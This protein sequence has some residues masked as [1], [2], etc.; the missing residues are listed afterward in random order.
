[1]TT[2][3][4]FAEMLWA[5][6]G[7]LDRGETDAA[8]AALRRQ[9]VRL[10]AL[11]TSLLDY[12]RIDPARPVIPVRPVR[13][14]TAIRRTLSQLPPPSSRRVDVA[15][16]DHVRL[17]ADEQHLDQ[18][19]VNLLGNA[20]RYGGRNIRIEAHDRDHHTELLVADDGPGIAP[21]FMSSLFEPFSRGAHA[22]ES[23]GSGLGLAIV[24]SLAVSLGGSVRYEPGIPAGARFVVSLRRAE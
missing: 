22:G 15:V 18:I 16:S 12:T 3:Y 17:L 24:R 19:L 23:A 4:G 11:V 2:V 1:M 13:P 20:Y 8:I 5:N 7:D 9:G 14:A 21:P 6:R 10:R